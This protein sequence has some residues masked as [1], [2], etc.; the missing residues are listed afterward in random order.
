M[1]LLLREVIKMKKIN[2]K[3]T[4]K[5]LEKLRQ[6]IAQ[7]PSPI[8]KMSKEEVIKTLRKTRE[9]LWEEKLAHHS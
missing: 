7:N 4:K 1:I 2:F 9:K 6:I 8:F 5:H 3:E